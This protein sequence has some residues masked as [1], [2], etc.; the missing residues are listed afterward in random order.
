M[1]EFT[2][3]HNL[4]VNKL[5]ER[6]YN[7]NKQPVFFK[8]FFQLC[9]HLANFRSGS[10]KILFTG[11]IFYQQSNSNLGLLCEKCGRYH[12]AIPYH[13]LSA[14]VLSLDDLSRHQLLLLLFEQHM[15][16]SFCKKSIIF[17]CLHFFSSLSIF[18]A[19]AAVSKC[20]EKLTWKQFELKTMRSFKTWLKSLS[21]AAVVCL[22]PP[23]T[24]AVL[25]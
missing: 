18:A 16:T 13:K 25:I 24:N 4:T 2:V 12:W 21:V 5:T 15:R 8:F 19:E 9:Y 11:S 3:T 23:S 1:F 7:V 22:L 14:D 20:K 10:L 6:K 17:S